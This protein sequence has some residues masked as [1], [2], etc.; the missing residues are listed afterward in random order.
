LAFWVVGDP[1]NFAR[2]TNGWGVPIVDLFE[3]VASSGVARA[4]KLMFVEYV[5]LSEGATSNIINI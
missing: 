4:S 2:E 5:T 1:T 3:T